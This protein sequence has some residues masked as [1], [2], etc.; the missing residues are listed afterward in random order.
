MSLSFIIALMHAKINKIFKNNKFIIG[1]VHLA[2]SLGFRNS[3]PIQEVINNAVY[4]AKVFED[5]G[6]DAVL[7]ENNYDLPHEINVSAGTAISM[8]KCI[9]ELK[10][11]IKIPIGVCVLWNDYKAALSLAKLYDLQF[12]RIAVFV[13]Y[14]ETDFGKIEA[15]HKELNEYKTLIGAADVL[16]FTDIQVKHSRL[17]NERPVGE[18]AHEAVEN[19]SDGIIVTGKWTGDAPEL[20]KVKNVRESINDF[21]VII[22]SGVD[23]NNVELLIQVADGVI[24]GTSVK[25]GNPKEKEVER[26]LKPHSYR[27]NKQKAQSLQKKLAEHLSV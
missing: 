16:V 3:P 22:G 1:M 13:D 6:Y 24:V 10:K 12:I 14:V 8:G 18:S 7:V 15:C 19:G 2:P 9:S 5:S 23:V 26:N 17:L 20:E 27:I 11:V 25:E 21:P 4:D